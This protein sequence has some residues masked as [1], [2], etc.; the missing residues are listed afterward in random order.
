MKYVIY[1]QEREKTQSFYKKAIAEYEKRLGRYCKAE[2]RFIRKEKQWQSLWKKAQTEKNSKE[3]GMKIFQIL[4]G[5][6][7]LTSEALSEKIGMWESSGIREIQFFVPEC[8]EYPEK[9]PG[10]KQ[11]QSEKEEEE[12]KIREHSSIKTLVL[13]DFTMPSAMTG[14]ILYEQIYRGYRILHQHPYHK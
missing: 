13:S 2:L 8:L 10:G 6:A 1:I 12:K 3:N 9:F 5:K 11:S 7:E 4:P 14:M